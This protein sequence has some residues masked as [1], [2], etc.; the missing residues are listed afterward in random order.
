ME[1][2]KPPVPA[3]EGD[4]GADGGEVDR[5]DDLYDAIAQSMA[6]DGPSLTIDI[7]SKLIR[8]KLQSPSVK[9]RG[10]LLD[11]CS[12]SSITCEADLNVIFRDSV[13]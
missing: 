6:A 13:L 1:L 11:L 2:N 10:Y 9:T 7:T 12:F 4:E 8:K 3:E 5:V